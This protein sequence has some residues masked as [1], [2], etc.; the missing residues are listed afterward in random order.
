MMKHTSFLHSTLNKT[1]SRNLL[2]TAGCINVGMYK[3][4]TLHS[5][6]LN[7]IT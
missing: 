3:G 7:K 4:R 5:E 2:H 1:K 6:K